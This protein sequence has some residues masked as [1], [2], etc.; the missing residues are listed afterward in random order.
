VTDHDPT[1]TVLVPHGDW[2]LCSIACNR[3]D[4]QPRW[5]SGGADPVLAVR[6]TPDGDTEALIGGP[7]YGGLWH[8]VDGDPETGGGVS[9]LIRGD[10]A[11]A[12]DSIACELK[13]WRFL[14]DEAP[15]NPEGNP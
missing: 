6:V 14:E 12:D 15:T 7:D 3:R 4:D 8:R 1:A 13:K 9:W 5:W 2:W 10:Q 11:D